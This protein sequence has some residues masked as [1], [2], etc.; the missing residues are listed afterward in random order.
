MSDSEDDDYQPDKAKKKTADEDKSE[1]WRS[2]TQQN[3]LCSSKTSSFQGSSEVS[4]EEDDYDDEDEEEEDDRPRKRKFIENDNV[5]PEGLSSD[6]NLL[7]V[8]HF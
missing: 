5:P 6:I 8:Q 2:K 7:S 3:F 1:V 4:D